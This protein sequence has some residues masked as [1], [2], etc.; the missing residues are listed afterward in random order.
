MTSKKIVQV[1]GRSPASRSLGGHQQVV[2]RLTSY[3]ES[4]GYETKI[5]TP[6]EK[7]RGN[8]SIAEGLVKVPS[9]ILSDMA[10]IP[11]L[12]GIKKIISAF[13]ETD[14]IHIHSPTTLFS[15]IATIISVFFKKPLVVTIL[16]YGGGLKHHKPSKRIL[17]IF[18]YFEQTFSAYL[19]DR[20]HVENIGDKERLSRF[21]EKTKIILPG[22]DGRFFSF[23]PGKSLYSRIV[24]SYG[25]DTSKRLLLYIGR[26]HEA[27]GVYDLIRALPILEREEQSTELMI[28]GP[29]R[30]NCMANIRKMA[31]ELEVKEKINYLGVV[32]EEEKIALMDLVDV[33]IVP[34]LSDVVEAYSLVASEA[35]SRNTPVVAYEVG[36]LKHRVKTKINGFLAEQKNPADLSRKI[37]RCLEKNLTPSPPKD[38]WS[39]EETFSEFRQVYDSLTPDRT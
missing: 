20:I 38:V 15:F 13:K 24:D 22:L 32:D 2:K 33:V 34:S 19:S 7:S 1:I 23:K 5:L 37:K 18:A 9:T 10:F 30:K 17:G 11:S 4:N 39:W 26:I 14:L 3:L 12:K 8:S 29:D 28:A 16:S 35:W 21:R 25:I 31:D 6:E 36:A 27:K